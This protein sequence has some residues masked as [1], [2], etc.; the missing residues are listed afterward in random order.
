MNFKPEIIKS[1]PINTLENKHL[2]EGV[3]PVMACISDRELKNNEF[4]KNLQEF[5]K[6]ATFIDYTKTTNKF[7][8][9]KNGYLSAGHNSYVISNIDNKNKYSNAYLDCTGLIVSGVDKKTKEP[10]S[11]LTHQDPSFFEK[12]KENKLKFKMDLNTRINELINRCEPDTI[13]AVVFGGSKIH[14]LNNVPDENYRKGIDDDSDFLKDEYS[15][16]INSVKFL[17]FIVSNQV[18]FSPVVLI[19]PNNNFNSP[20][21]T[22]GEYKH[23]LSVYF[24]N[25]NKRVYAVRPT[26]NTI[27]NESFLAKDVYD[28]ID[29]IKKNDAKK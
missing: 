12:S 26:Q 29:K 11:F 9:A 3:S 5:K 2:K 1:E 13:D 21:N 15:D 27:N 25:K 20:E 14:D 28:Q 23:S 10:I 7:E 19:G 17:N 8:L 18:N 24:D 16:Y 6:D 4:W 22:M